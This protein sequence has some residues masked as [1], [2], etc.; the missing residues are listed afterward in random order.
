MDSHHRVLAQLELDDSSDPSIAFN[1]SVLNVSDAVRPG[2]VE[3]EHIGQSA[4]RPVPIEGE[5]GRPDLEGRDMAGKNE[6]H[7]I[8]RRTAEVLAGVRPETHG[9]AA[10]RDVDDRIRH[11]DISDGLRRDEIQAAGRRSGRIQRV[12]VRTAGEITEQNSE[13]NKTQQKKR[14]WISSSPLCC[15]MAVMRSHS[16]FGQDDSGHRITSSSVR[17]KPREGA[18]REAQG[19]IARLYPASRAMSTDK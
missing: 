11:G 14:F 7:G 13:R 10:P 12:F 9:L 8:G 17:R 19:K 6:V 16:R 4:T 3:G 5:K 1:V 15:T 2:R 18:S